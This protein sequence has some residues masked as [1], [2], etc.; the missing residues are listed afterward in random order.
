MVTTK[1]T[2]AEKFKDLL[3]NVRT[4]NDDT[5][6]SRRRAITRRLNQDFWDSY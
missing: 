4:Q 2:I 1:R 3:R 6:A 5:V